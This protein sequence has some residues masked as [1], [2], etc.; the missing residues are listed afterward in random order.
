MARRGKL[1]GI[2]SLLFI[3][4]CSSHTN[5]DTINA[6]IENIE[7]NTWEA[8]D[9]IYNADTFNHPDNVLRCLG[10]D[11]AYVWQPGE[12][13]ETLQNQVS[14]TLILTVNNHHKYRFNDLIH[15]IHLAG[16]L[17][18]NAQ[19]ETIV[20]APGPV[21]VCIPLDNLPSGK[22][23]AAIS[24]QSSSGKSFKYSWVFEK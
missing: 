22:H 16:T 15:Y 3:S 2:L 4:A 20:R 24:F 13:V 18:F 14:S 17:R 5:S 1:L 6:T 11:L 9:F 10:I 8:P 21:Y 19:D 23:L 7:S 12:A